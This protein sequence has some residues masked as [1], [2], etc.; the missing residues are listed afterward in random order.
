MQEAG[1]KYT[2][3]WVS[4]SSISDFLKCPRLYFLKN[5]YRNPDT[6]HKIKLMTPPLALGQA[7]HEVLDSISYLSSTERF[8]ESLV[9]KLEHSWIRWSG[10]K[11]GFVSD[12]SEQKYKKRAQ[13]ILSRVMKHPGPLKN[14]AVKITKTDIPWF[15]LSQEANIILCGKI[16]WLEYLTDTESVRVI[17]FKTSVGEEPPTSLQLPIYYLLA[18]H[19]QKYPV[20]ALSYWYLERQAEPQEMPLPEP[21]K[22]TEKILEIAK[23]IKTTRQ[24]KV[25][26]CLH[27]TGCQAC[28]PYEA[29]VNKKAEFVG[30]SNLNED[31]YIRDQSSKDVQEEAVIL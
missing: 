2:A 26:K 22:A 13:D 1:D 21:Q 16:D 10:R 20:T 30:T 12:E 23:K 24:L 7:V 15:W 8:K 25:F 18:S 17:D 5:I 11:G 27:K 6:G 4:H 29:I 28:K 14:L 9:E 31:I 3:V 19:C